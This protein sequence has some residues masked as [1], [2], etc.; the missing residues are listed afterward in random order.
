MSEL[1]SKGIITL[2]ALNPDMNVKRYYTIRIDRNLFGETSISTS[3]GRIGSKGQLK[4][5]YFESPEAGNTFLHSTL[6]KTPKL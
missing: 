3:Y 4:H 6:K 2:K 1:H 5:D